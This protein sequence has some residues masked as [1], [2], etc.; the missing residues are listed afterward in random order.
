MVTGRASLYRAPR[1]ARRQDLEA[2]SLAARGETGRRQPNP[3]YEAEARAAR[4][5]LAA[6][7]AAWG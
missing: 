2:A 3:E 1:G 5:L 4:E 7:R 6:V